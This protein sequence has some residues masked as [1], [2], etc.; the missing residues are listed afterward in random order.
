MDKIWLVARHEYRRLVRKRDFLLLTLAVP[1]G[2]AVLIAV[3]MWIAVGEESRLPVGYVDQHGFLD[4]ARRPDQ[5]GEAQALLP[6]TFPN[7]AAALAALENGEIQAF[8]VFPPDYLE[9]L[10]TDLYYLEQPPGSKAWQALDDFVRQNLLAG[11]PAAVRERLLDGAEITVHDIASGRQFSEAG[12]INIIL[13]FAASLL[14]L[15]AT[16]SASGNM[17]Q[18]VTDEKENRTMEILLTSLTP[19]QLIGGKAAGLLAVSLTQLAIYAAAIVIGI[20]I[21]APYVAPLQQARVP[22]DYLGMILLFFLPSYALF[23]A[24]MVAI[25]AAAPDLQQGQQIAGFLNLVFVAPMLLL[26]VLFENPAS[27]LVIFLSLFPPTAFLTLSLRWGL[28]SVAFWQL[29]LAW[30]LL[31]ATTL[32][33]TWL[34]ARLFRIGMLRYGQPLRWKA[35]VATLREG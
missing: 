19:G 17:L 7:Q 13:P 1:L 12:I 8:F 24:V 30:V 14:F 6:R 22:W 4:P 28:G 11:Y 33:V 5:P 23:S 34:A 21:A 3:S 35:I 16:M 18:A 15:F 27:P 9:T 25:G 2:M 32:F 29:A 10:R 26:A 31:I 20:L